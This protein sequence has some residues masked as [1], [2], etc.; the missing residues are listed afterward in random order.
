MHVSHAMD[1][2]LGLLHQRLLDPGMSVTRQRDP[3][4]PCKVYIDVSVHITNVGT[5]R[6]LPKNRKS[7]DR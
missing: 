5:P 3:K 4:G 6:F 1:E 2:P 7:S